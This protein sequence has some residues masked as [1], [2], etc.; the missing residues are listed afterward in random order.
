[1]ISVTVDNV[2]VA[3]N[4]TLMV[5]SYGAYFSDAGTL[6]AGPVLGLCDTSAAPCRP[7]ASNPMYQFSAGY[8][9]TAPVIRATKRQVTFSFTFQDS[10]LGINGVFSIIGRSIQLHNSLDI[11]VAE[12]SNQSDCL[13]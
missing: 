5:H 2:N 6:T 13:C 3:D 10:L 7:T 1:L 4:Y 11:P 8:L 9:P 12:C